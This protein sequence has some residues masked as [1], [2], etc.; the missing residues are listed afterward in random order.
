MKVKGE[1]NST[2]TQKVSGLNETNVS[3]L[4]KFFV[5]ASLAFSCLRIINEKPVKMK[6]TQSTSFVSN[7]NKYVRPVVRKISKPLSCHK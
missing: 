4:H 1:R 7:A 6:L 2:S 5:F 3:G